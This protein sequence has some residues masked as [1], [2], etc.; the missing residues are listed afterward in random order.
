MIAFTCLSGYI[1]SVALVGVNSGA[2]LSTFFTQ[3]TLQDLYGGELKGFVRQMTRLQ[4]VLGS[5]QDAEVASAR[6][7]AL[8]LTEEGAEQTSSP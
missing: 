2:F 1:A 8:A 3:G 7:Q 6:L 5:M 4:D